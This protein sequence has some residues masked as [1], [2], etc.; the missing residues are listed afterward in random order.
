MVLA[1]ISKAEFKAHALEVLRRVE[2]TQEPV[3][4]TDR[5]RPVVRIEPFYG[6]D[7][8]AVL[9][10]LRGTVRAYHDPTAPVADAGW[11]ALTG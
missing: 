9:A 8:V 3:L 1:R 2:A 4:V 10:G 7:D 5:G 11:E 6:E